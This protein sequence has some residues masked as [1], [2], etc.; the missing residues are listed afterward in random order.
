MVEMFRGDMWV[1]DLVYVEVDI[2]DI[3]FKFAPKI[4]DILIVIELAAFTVDF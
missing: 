1:V 3:L 2:D 4:D